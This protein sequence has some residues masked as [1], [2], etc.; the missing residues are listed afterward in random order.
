MSGWFH[1]PPRLPQQ[2]RPSIA[3]EDVAIGSPN[4]YVGL[5]PRINVIV[6]A[7]WGQES[8][9]AQ[10]SPTVASQLATVQMRAPAP[11]FR[12]QAFQAIYRS[13][14][15]SYSLLV[16]AG[17]VSG[18]DVVAPP[19]P[20]AV[21]VP[22]SNASAVIRI[23]WP[24]PQWEA[25]AESTLASIFATPANQQTY[26]APAAAL[27]QID[28]VGSWP[29][30]DWRAQSEIA[31]AGGFAPIQPGPVVLPN[32][33]TF[34][35]LLATG[36][37]PRETWAAQS[38]VH[39]LAWLP[40]PVTAIPAPVPHYEARLWPTEQWSAQSSARIA[41]QLSV[42]TQQIPPPQTALQAAISAA[43]PREQWPAQTEPGV[44]SGL[45]SIVP[46]IFVPKAPSQQQIVANWPQEQWPAQEGADVASQFAQVFTI[47]YVASG[48]DQSVQYLWPREQWNAQ[49]ASQSAALFAQQQVAPIYTPRSTVAQQAA[50]VST[51][52][53]EAWAAQFSPPRAAWIPPLV[54]AI[55][56]P[57][58]HIER[59]LWPQ[60]QW[61]AQ[62]GPHIASQFATA[63]QP[64]PVPPVQ[65][66]IVS[67]WPT[68]SWK[69]QSG[70]QVASQFALVFDIPFIP[71]PL[72]TELALSW[73][74][75]SW[76]AQTG[77]D[78]AS[79]L[80]SAP[81]PVSPTV[82]TSVG[83]IRFSWPQEDWKHQTGSRNAATFAQAPPVVPYISIATVVG[84][85]YSWP[86]E[87]WRAQSAPALAYLSA[88]VGPPPP[89]TPGPSR[90]H[91]P[92]ANLGYKVTTSTFNLLD[93]VT[94]SWGSEF[95]APDH[96]VYE[97]SNGRGFDSTDLGTT[98]IYRKK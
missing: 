65:Q 73:P 57:P 40:K 16:F 4:V 84:L 66:Q 97:F 54:T 58:P 11:P 60:E 19:P 91:G 13:H 75:E 52:P 95:R 10:S 50:L 55:P 2:L 9:A 8:W 85:V 1:N 76:A 79:E 35:A 72:R 36:L 68:E 20:Q 92:P 98:G 77:A 44:A 82:P 26:P 89:P 74:Q 23:S 51:W 33:L 27:G 21:S 30:P 31:V 18:V 49:R 93:M 64:Q 34:A 69:A 25:Q 3:P 61:P 56:A 43:W 29:Q 94:R 15:K 24:E 87:I 70:A 32:H 59:L 46:P 90:P 22:L 14:E 28:T 88:N 6:R 38:P 53:L 39:S 78:V 80:T 96:R 67:I 83:T 86:Q 7:A 17:G 81:V 62:Q 47:I 63:I 42:L 12:S 37:W 5:I 71:T 45:A 48:E 41:G